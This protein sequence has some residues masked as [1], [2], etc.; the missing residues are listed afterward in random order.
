MSVNEE[1]ARLTERRDIVARDIEEL[2]EQVEAG[3]IDEATAAD[4]QAR[5]TQDLADVEARLAE[6]PKEQKPKGST[7]KTAQ[8][9]MSSSDSESSGE[10]PNQ[11]WSPKRVLVAGGILVA[12]FTVILVVVLSAANRQSTTTTTDAMSATLEQMEAAVAANP[13][14]IGMRIA[15]ADQYFAADDFSNALDHY[16]TVLDSNPTDEEASH[17]LGRVGW[18]AYVTG[19][20]D[21]AVD[22]LNQSLEKDPANLEATLFLGIDYLYG[23]N[24]AESALPLL[25]TV[26]DDPDIPSD[27]KS[28]IQ[29]AIDDANAA[30]QS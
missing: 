13:D 30:L 16:L 18:L 7:T 9:D 20:P 28:Q 5:Y 26:M 14:V 8:A 10:Q 11:G 15:L 2:A 4:L 29:T 22:Y 6:L 19:Q 1:R 24:D 27:L 17:V 21:A 23:L 3:E 12:A 25:Q